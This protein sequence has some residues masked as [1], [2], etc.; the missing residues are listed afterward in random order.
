MKKG[1]ESM[2]VEY[3]EDNPDHEKYPFNLGSVHG[4][5]DYVS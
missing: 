3:S 5:R 2:E 4:K 1:I